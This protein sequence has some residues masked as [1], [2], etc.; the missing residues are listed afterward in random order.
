METPRKIKLNFASLEA[1]Y[2]SQCSVQA[3]T[4]EVFLNFAASLLPG[5]E[6]GEYILPVHTR[7]AMNYHTA[8][9]LTGVLQ[10]TVA[11]YEEENGPLTEMKSSSEIPVEQSKRSGFPKIKK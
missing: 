11:K 7:M 10:A 8:K 1:Q 2:V 3:T 4:Q 6:P 5:S 9:R